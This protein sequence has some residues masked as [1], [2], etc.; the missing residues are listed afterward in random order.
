MIF[1]KITT[2]HC[3]FTYKVLHGRVPCYVGQLVL[4]GICLANTRLC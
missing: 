2:S 1:T 3:I 4:V